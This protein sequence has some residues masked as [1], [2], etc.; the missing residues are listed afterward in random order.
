MRVTQGMMMQTLL[1]NIETN[2]ARVEQLQSQITSGSRITKPSDDPIGAARALNLQESLHQSEQYVRNIDQAS[3]WLN[4]TDSVLDSVTKTIHRAVELTTQAANDTMSGQDRTAILEEIRQIQQHVLNLSRSKYGASY[5]FSGTHSDQVGYVTANPSPG[6][7]Q[8]ND[9]EI[10]REVA[11]GV[12]MGVNAN[13]RAT[14]DPIFTAL[15]NIEAG[16]VAND[17][18]ALS[19]TLTNLDTALD[20]V[21]ISRAALGA[22]T[23]RLDLLKE[24]Q[25]D[26]KVNL[27]G[28]LSEVKDADMAEALTNFSMAQTV[29]QA[30]LKAGAQAM[31]Q[32]LLDYLR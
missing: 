19:G 30:S 4:T 29:Y 26:I 11:P 9:G 25:E 22:K 23:N 7:Y 32:S 1:H 18:S 5:L 17:A 12:S 10:L 27:T 3:S 6:G 15:N 28:L 24:R 16:L 31:Q 13:A 8:G 2:Q 14:F 21:N 20:A